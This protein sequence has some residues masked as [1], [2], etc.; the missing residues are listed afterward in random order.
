MTVPLNLANPAEFRNFLGQLNLVT[1]TGRVADVIGVLIESEGPVASI[2]EYCEIHS[3][4]GGE[5]IPCEVVGFRGGRVLLMPFGEMI[6]ICPGTE[7]RAFG[8]PISAMVSDGIVGRILDGLGNPIDG[9]GPV[10]DAVPVPVHTS[11]PKPLSRR[12]ITQPLPLGIRSIDGLLTCGRG[13][14]MGI[15]SGSGVGK[16]SVLGMIARFTRA[17]VSVIGLIGERGREVREFLERDLGEEGLARSVVVVATSDQSALMRIKGAFTAT[18]VAE[19]FRDRG[20]DVILMIDSITRFAF[21]QREL[22]LSRGEPPTTRGY[23]PS[24]FSVL[25]KLLER[26]GTSDKGSITGLYNVLVEADDM[27][28]PVADAIRAI[29]DG[30]VVLSRDLA[31]R[32]VYPSVD[33]LQSV[34]RVMIDVVSERHLQG[35]R[36]LSETLAVYRDAEDLINIGAYVKGSNPAID[37]AAGKIGGIYDFIRQGLFEKVDYEDT[38]AALTALFE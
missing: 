32:G 17:D 22:G 31:Q 29:L 14:R 13:Q 12:R 10:P 18:A 8:R 30:H 24:L 15:F 20:K 21:A 35:A 36:K 28:E 3:R 19:Y 23:T 33:V 9:K 26:S 6:G 5:T 2:G 16:S 11:P 25:P 4:N 27:N 7:V 37:Y 34:S 1:Q 38:Q